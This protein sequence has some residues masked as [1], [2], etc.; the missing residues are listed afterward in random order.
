MEDREI[1]TLYIRRNHSALEET[2]AKYRKYL[3][4]IAMNI[5]GNEDDSEEC[6][7]DVYM[8]A[9]TSVPK[10]KP[11]D[12]KLYL[13]RIAKNKA[14]NMIDK[15]MAKKRG[16]GQYIHAIDELGDVVSEKDNPEE[17]YMQKVDKEAIESFL[18]NLGEL[19]R[20]IFIRRYWFGDSAA[21]IGR[22]YDISALSVNLK[23]HRTRKKLKQYILDL[24]S[25]F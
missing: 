12:L 9:W 11:D 6:L 15:K 14:L 20:K 24:N 21:D 23:L 18:D 19:E 4:K 22:K 10:Q 1:M 17:Q 7:N 3:L 5:L 16:G 8:S 13:A 25:G 2:D